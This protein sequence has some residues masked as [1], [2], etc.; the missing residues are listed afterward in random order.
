MAVTIGDLNS[1]GHRECLAH[2]STAHFC[3]PKA[4]LVFTMTQYIFRSRVLRETR[5]RDDINRRIGQTDLKRKTTF[6]NK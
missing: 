6:E 5:G 4:I 1:D 2:L 3:S